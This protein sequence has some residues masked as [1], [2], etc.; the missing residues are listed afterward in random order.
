MLNLEVYIYGIDL[1]KNR[2]LIVAMDRQVNQSSVLLLL[3]D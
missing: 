2:F 1:G 3:L